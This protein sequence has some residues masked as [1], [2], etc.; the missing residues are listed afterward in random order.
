LA[1]E[2]VLKRRCQSQTT[3]PKSGWQALFQLMLVS[4]SLLSFLSS[5]AQRAASDATFAKSFMG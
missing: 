3:L 2:G 4:L 1:I 5:L